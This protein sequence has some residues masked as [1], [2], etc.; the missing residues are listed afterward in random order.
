MSIFTLQ[1]NLNDLKISLNMGK[2][3]SYTDNLY[4]QAFE[5]ILEV[6]EREALIIENKL[7]ID[8]DTITKRQ[9]LLLDNIKRYLEDHK[10]EDNIDKIFNKELLEEFRNFKPDAMTIAYKL[11]NL[12]GE[13]I[14][15]VINTIGI[16]RFGFDG[17]I[18]Y[19]Y[20]KDKSIVIIEININKAFIFSIKRFSDTP[21]ICGTGGEIKMNEELEKIFYNSDKK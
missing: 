7:N 12:S 3:T 13:D 14:R 10:S 11:V 5:R 4:K 17:Q 18:P 16:D 9:E 1:F 8:N 15:E 6:V 2:N 19:L 20:L 21:I